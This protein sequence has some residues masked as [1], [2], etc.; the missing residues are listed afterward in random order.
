VL[1]A[2]LKK[3]IHK[4]TIWSTTTFYGMMIAYYLMTSPNPN[5]L[6]YLKVSYAV[7][8][9]LSLILFHLKHRILKNNN[10]FGSNTIIKFERIIIPVSALFVF[11][12]GILNKDLVGWI[13]IFIAIICSYKIL[14]RTKEML[15][16][17]Y[18]EI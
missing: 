4:L 11:V 6:L 12:A 2:E 13:A 5:I 14:A 7:D 3:K 10:I 18:S 1:E 15:N 16:D 9:I 8:L 17:N